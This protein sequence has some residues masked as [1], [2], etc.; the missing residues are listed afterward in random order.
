[1][2]AAPANDNADPRTP[3]LLQELDTTPVYPIIHTIKEVR[4]ETSRNFSLIK[5]ERLGYHG[6]YDLDVTILD[7]D[8]WYDGE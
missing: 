3:L 7:A 2:Q 6:A 8:I 1:M 5:T 4:P